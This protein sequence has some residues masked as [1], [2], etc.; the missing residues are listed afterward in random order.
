MVFGN[1]CS[2]KNP[3]VPSSFIPGWRVCY[4]LSCFALWWF[5]SDATNQWFW[6]EY[7]PSGILN[8]SAYQNT[9]HLP[10]PS[11]PLSSLLLLAPHAHF[12]NGCDWTSLILTSVTVSTLPHHMISWYYL[13]WNC[14]LNQG[15][16][17]MYQ[18]SALLVAS[19]A[20]WLIWAICLGLLTILV[21]KCISPLVPTP[22]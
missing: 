10:W 14:K 20:T 16:I 2:V 5:L 3:V 11:M 17:Q 6:L 22:M 21:S 13:P 19:H 8:S 12:I 7:H 15:F 4:G 1:Y 18:V 9:A